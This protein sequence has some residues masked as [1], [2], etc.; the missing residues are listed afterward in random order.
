MAKAAPLFRSC[1][2]D[3][4]VDFVRGGARFAFA[5]LGMGIAFQG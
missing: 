4:P 1:E 3:L 5:P 2:Q